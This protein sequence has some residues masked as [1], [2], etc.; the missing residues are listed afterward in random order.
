MITTEGP[1]IPDAKPMALRQGETAVVVLDMN[2]ECEDPQ[3]K[4]HPLLERVSA[5]LRRARQHN[6]PIIYTV[7]LMNKGNALGEVA[8]SLERR[9]DEPVLYPDGFDKFTGGEL[10]RLL[11]PRGVKNIVV[12]GRSTNVAV[13]YTATV[14]ARVHKFQVVIPKDGVAANGDYEHT[15]ALHQLS[16]LPKSV[17]VPVAFSRLD[18][19]E[20]H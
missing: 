17:T 19:I 2:S 12:V 10:E 13:M 11:R 5:F 9:Q 8:A 1:S 20:F 6:V 14:A 18:Q 7:S 3:A 4:G 15:Y 16:R